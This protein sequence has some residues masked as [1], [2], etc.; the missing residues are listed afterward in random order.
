[1]AGAFL[2]N[3]I[4]EQVLFFGASRA[5]LIDPK[6]IPITWKASLLC[7]DCNV[8]KNFLMK[9]WSCPPY[10]PLLEKTKKILSD[11]NDALVVNIEAKFWPLTNHSYNTLNPF[12]QIAQK[13]FC[14]YYWRKLH[15]IMLQMKWYLSQE[16]DVFSWGS[17]P[18]HG[19]FKC[20]YPFRCRK[21]KLFLFSPE[22]S[23]IDLYSLAKRL[24]LP[25]EIPP[26][27]KIQLLSLLVFCK[28]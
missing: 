25:I 7:L 13:I 19:C 28:K 2:S 26:R 4:I 6:E 24:G 18:C 10:S 20:S 23:G 21:S 12:Y 16:Y 11:Y 17:S 8:S 3:K 22:A 27:N 14:H 9:R 5:Y 1:M 15:F